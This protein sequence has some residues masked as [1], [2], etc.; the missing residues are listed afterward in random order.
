VRF[1]R[2]R[3]RHFPID[4]VPKFLVANDGGPETLALRRGPYRYAALPQ[5][6]V[7]TC[8]D[9]QYEAA[10]NPQIARPTSFPDRESLKQVEQ[11]VLAE[12]N[13]AISVTCTSPIFRCTSGTF[14]GGKSILSK[15]ADAG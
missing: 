15:K 12:L 10:S 2:L 6:N 3:G 11:A 1:G 7:S 5:Y 4:V 14:S 13:A 9:N 8:G